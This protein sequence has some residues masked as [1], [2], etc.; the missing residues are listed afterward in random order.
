MGNV[1]STKKS[2]NHPQPNYS[3]G[4]TN[5]INQQPPNNKCCCIHKNKF[6]CCD[7]KC[8]RKISK[9]QHIQD[10]SRVIPIADHNIPNGMII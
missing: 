4:Y 7:P 10:S 3:N 6:S 2:R 5:I 1:F 8:N 9:K